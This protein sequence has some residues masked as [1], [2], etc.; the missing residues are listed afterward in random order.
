MLRAAVAAKTPLGLEAK[1]AMDA[2]ALV[3]DEIVVGLIGE[4]VTAPACRVGFILDGFPRTV[5]QAA[6]L[7]AM[8]AAKGQHI[9]RVLNF[10]VPDQL[11]VREKKKGGEREERKK[12]RAHAFFDGRGGGGGGGGGGGVAW[13]HCLVLGIARSL[14]RLC[15]RSEA[16][17]G[18]RTKR[19]GRPPLFFFGLSH[20]SPTLTPL[21]FLSFF[22]L[23]SPPIF[24]SAK[25]ERVT[26][27]LIHAASGRSYHDKFA[28]P[29]VPGVDDVT[30]EP[31]TRRKDDNAE[32]L[33]ARLAAFHA[34]TAPVIDHYREKVVH[35]KADR[36]MGDV[37]ADIR[38]ALG[39]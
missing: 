15:S 30:G 18:P 26:G 10:K 2:G 35:L 17:A 16:R 39:H 12:T 24:L 3:S 6:K 38:K 33:K 21:F 37:A 11:L 36:G 7:D 31:L 13:A 28:P 22:F 32:T 29:K 5:A 8:L 20:P 14:L 23:F 34:Q 9:D 4:A 1:K 19:E 25:V 27:R